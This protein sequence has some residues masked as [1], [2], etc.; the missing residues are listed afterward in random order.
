MVLLLGRYERRLLRVHL[1]EGLPAGLPLQRTLFLNVYI[2]DEPHTGKW[3]DGAGNEKILM[4]R[5]IIVFE[6]EGYSLL[7][8]TPCGRLGKRYFWRNPPESQVCV[9]LGLRRAILL[10]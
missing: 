8:C 9:P 6:M 5:E 7:R 2:F 3:I 10:T 4:E 1:D